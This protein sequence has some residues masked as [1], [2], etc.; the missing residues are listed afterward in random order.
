M[1][2]ISKNNIIL[3]EF[4]KGFYDPQFTW[5]AEETNGLTEICQPLA[6]SA[7]YYDIPVYVLANGIGQKSKLIYI[8]NLCKLTLSDIN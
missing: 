2:T 5:D 8:L 7:A 6:Q 4:L 3:G 1:T